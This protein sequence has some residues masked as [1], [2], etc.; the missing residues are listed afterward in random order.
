MADYDN[1]NKGVIFKNT[2]KQEGDKLPMYKGKG[3]YDGKDFEIALWVNT[4]KDGKSYFSAKFSAPYVKD[5]N[6]VKEETPKYNN[7]SQQ[8]EINNDDELQNLPF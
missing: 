5:A 1:T 4:D 7:N 2:Y 3:N 6:S 8:R